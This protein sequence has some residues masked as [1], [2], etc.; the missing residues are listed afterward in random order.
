ML[1]LVQYDTTIVLVNR[2]TDLASRISGLHGEFD[3]SIV[4][5]TASVKHFGFA[6]F[7]LF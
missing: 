6:G 7:S 3:T 2:S 1:G 4:A 5:G